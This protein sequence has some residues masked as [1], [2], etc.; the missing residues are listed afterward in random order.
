MHNVQPIDSGVG[1]GGGGGVS[2]TVPVIVRVH[3]AKEKNNKK[4]ALMKIF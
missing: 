2:R 1:W 3:K 4:Q